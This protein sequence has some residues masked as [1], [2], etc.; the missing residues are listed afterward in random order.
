M[1]SS[2]NDLEII[3]VD[4][5]TT[6]VT[7]TSAD[8]VSS[9][10]HQNLTTPVQEQ[11]KVDSQVVEAGE[12][13]DASHDLT[14][15]EKAAKSKT[16]IREVFSY[17]LV[18][19]AAFIFA[20][21]T[22]RYLIVNARIPTGSMVPT[23][24]EGTRIVGNRLAY[25][26]S[27]PKRGD[28][29]IFYYPDNEEEKYIKRVI[30]LPGEKVEIIN[31][32]VYINDVFLDESAYLTVVPV[33]SFGPYY[34]PENSYFMLGDNRNSSRDSR[35]WTNTFVN[36]NKIIAKALFSYYPKIGKIK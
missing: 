27:V 12:L 3:D 21:L 26:S 13:E 34:V 30:G 33:G 15:E 14:P 24:K 4:L 18:V 2:N 20:T 35:F 22:N 5:T 8:E 31:G 7:N 28:I 32:E 17:I 23:I 1:N 10:S 36:K 6:E 9:V 11:H 29:V 19:A 16:I 25:I